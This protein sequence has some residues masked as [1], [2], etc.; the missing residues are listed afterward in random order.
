MTDT[1]AL[2]LPLDILS[3]V[4]ND[5]ANGKKIS[6][7]KKVRNNS[8]PKPRGLK[9]AKYAVERLEAEM[10][11]K[12]MSQVSPDAQA[13][14]PNTLIKSVKFELNGGELEVD[15]DQ[16]EM[17]ALMGLD[18]LG[19]D[20]VSRILDL[21]KI[22]KAFSNGTNIHIGSVNDDAIDVDLD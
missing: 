13:I 22:L 7:I 5:L 19:I 6:A 8:K 20:E 14:R 11:L 18:S 4:K 21:V 9:E 16:M 15:L 2:H 1:H 17:R 3:D 12:P 10:G